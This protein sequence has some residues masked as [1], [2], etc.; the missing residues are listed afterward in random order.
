MSSN[1]RRLGIAVVGV[2]IAVLGVSAARMGWDRVRAQAI[3]PAAP[4]ATIVPYTVVLR[5]IYTSASGKAVE[6]SSQTWAVRS[7]GARALKLGEGDGGTRI[8]NLPDGTRIEVSD[9]HRARSTTR[10]PYEGPWLRNP[11]SMCASPPS[12]ATDLQDTAPTVEPVQGHRAAKFTRKSG[13]YWYALDAGCAPIKRR[14]N[15]AGGGHS[16]LRLVSLLV[17]EPSEALFAAP[18]GY[19]EGSPS[20][21]ITRPEDCDAVCAERTERLIERLD[22]QYNQH[23]VP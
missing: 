5:E 20:R 2:S 7:D 17:G 16:D 19:E 6:A 15:F 13:E 9:F 21:F 8:I 10:K 3:G 4:G 11:A 18:A 23:R 14:L 12:N 1:L 22:A